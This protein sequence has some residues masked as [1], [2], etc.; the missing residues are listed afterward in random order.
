MERFREHGE[1]AKAPLQPVMGELQEP[2]GPVTGIEPR[3]SC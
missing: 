1:K 3:T 2:K